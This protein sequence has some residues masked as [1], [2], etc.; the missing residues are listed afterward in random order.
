MRT[1]PTHPTTSAGKSQNLR[2]APRK[3]PTAPS[4]RSGAGSGTVR[5]PVENRL[6]PGH[7]VGYERYTADGH[8]ANLAAAFLAVAVSNGLNRPFTEPSGGREAFLLVEHD[9]T[10][11]AVLHNGPYS[12]HFNARPAPDYDASGS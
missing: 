10:F 6:P 5:S 8:Y 1:S 3:P 11:R 4:R 9:P 7:R 2:D 12:L